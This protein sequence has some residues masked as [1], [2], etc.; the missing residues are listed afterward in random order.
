MCEQS[1]Q[2]EDKQEKPSTTT[3]TTTPE[4][5]M[6][7]PACV[8]SKIILEV[9]CQA[10]RENLMKEA[11]QLFMHAIQNA[12][13]LIQSYIE[14]AKMEEEAGKLKTSKMILLEGLEQA[15]LSTSLL[16]KVLRLDEKQGNYN[17]ARQLLGRLRYVHI[18][19]AWR[20]ILEGASLEAR[21]G[22][23]VI[24]RKI[25]KYLMN[26]VPFYG[27]VFHE[28]SLLEEKWNN[29]EAAIRICEQGLILNPRYAPL[30]ITLIRL[31]EK[32]ACLL[33]PHSP[34]LTATRDAVSLALE[35]IPK[36][37]STHTQWFI[38]IVCSI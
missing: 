31:H 30:Y 32:L 5:K 11:R 27:N 25:Y 15:P 3:T 34:D 26:N 35:N 28:A 21:A 38:S 23:L 29:I 6:V 17:A 37:S 4:G 1:S 9:A 16:V 7:V 22:R 33:N 13:H 19:K 36:V 10:K 18:H 24:A 14:F 8:Y 2:Y 20:V 12:P